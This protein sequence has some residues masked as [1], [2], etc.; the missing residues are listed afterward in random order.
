MELSAELPY[1]LRLGHTIGTIIIACIVMVLEFSRWRNNRPRITLHSY[2]DWIYPANPDQPIIVLKA[3][4][5]SPVA[6]RVTGV[7]LNFC[8]SRWHRVVKSK[9]VLSSTIMLNPNEEL[10]IASITSPWQ[11]TVW[12]NE[13]ITRCLENEY[14]YAIVQFTHRKR[15]VI[16]RIKRNKMATMATR[17]K[18]LAPVPPPA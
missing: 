14:V 10:N 13:E 18:R 15:P 3:V 7:F 8:P 17:Q 11:Q 16:K 2:T 9:E 5:R 12:Q 4:N 1:V 6:T